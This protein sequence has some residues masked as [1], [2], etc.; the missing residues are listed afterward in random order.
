MYTKVDL[1]EKYVINL[2]DVKKII[3]LFTKVESC[4]MVVNKI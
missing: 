3:E 1:L 4:D 2:L